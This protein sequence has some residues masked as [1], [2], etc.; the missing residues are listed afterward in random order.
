MPASDQPQYPQDHFLKVGNLQVRYWAEGSQGTQVILIHGL[1]GYVENWWP[2]ILT[3][4]RQ[5]RVF[6]VDLPGFGRSEKPPGASYDLI[7]FAQFIHDFMVCLGIEKASLVGH[8]MGGAIAL[9][10]VL[11]YSQLVDRLVLVSSGGLGREMSLM[12]RLA[13]L[14]ILGEMLTRPSLQG[15]RQ[16]IK[17]L[18]YDPALVIDED[19]RYDYELSSLPG[20]Q[21]AFLKTLRS[22]GDLYGQ[23]RKIIRPILGNLPAISQ[24]TLVFW[25]RQ[26][27]IVP[28]KHANVA[29]CIPQARMEIFDRCGHIPQFEHPARFDQVL[30][31]FL[32]D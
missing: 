30:Q 11:S 22:L 10:V 23:K 29:C 17:M 18:I 16:F 2:N 1:G 32:M 31:E 8:S 19:V 13:C 27:T 3:L 14:P 5:H 12:L 9:Q 4:A 7:Y 26:D 28:V 25:G 20:A 6:A 15:S 24:P 21:Q